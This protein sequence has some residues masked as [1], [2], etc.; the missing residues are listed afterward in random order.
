MHDLFDEMDGALEDYS[1]VE[2]V[3]LQASAPRARD[4]FRPRSA[5]RAA[6]NARRTAA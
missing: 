3:M 2:E 1:A 4:A 6:C 5:T